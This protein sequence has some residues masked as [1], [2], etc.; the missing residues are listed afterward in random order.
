M[1]LPFNTQT[2]LQGVA[3][4]LWTSVLV[5]PG[6]LEDAQHDL[7]VNLQWQLLPEELVI[8]TGCLNYIQVITHLTKASGLLSNT[9][10]LLTVVIAVD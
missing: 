1:Y 7:G 10:F 6:P 4:A 3:V 2:K 5:L 8:L 9:E